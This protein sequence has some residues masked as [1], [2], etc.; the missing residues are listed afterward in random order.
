MSLKYIL[1]F[2]IIILIIDYVIAKNNK[3]KI[4]YKD[5]LNNNYNARTLPPFYIVILKSEKENQN[6]LHHELVHW[7]QYQKNGAIIYYLKYLSKHFLYGYDKNSMEIEARKSTNE[8]EFCLHNYTECVKNGKSN[9][10]KNINFR[11]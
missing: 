4:I 3:P 10:V 5:K 6:L 7:K 1:L 8:T 2:I 11:K 9:T